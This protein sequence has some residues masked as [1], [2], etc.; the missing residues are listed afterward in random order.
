MFET[1]NLSVKVSS[2]VTPY[3]F[4]DRQPKMYVMD[5]DGVFVPECAFHFSTCDRLKKEGV[6][7]TTL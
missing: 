1:S 3:L 2:D 6:D 7:F 4:C 5:H